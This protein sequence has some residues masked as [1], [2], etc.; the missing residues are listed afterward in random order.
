M[1]NSAKRSISPV[2]LG[3]A[4][5]ACASCPA[6]AQ[7]S[8]EE[9]L[10]QEVVVTAQFRAQNLQRTPI[11][12]T[13]VNAEMMDA[14]S[15]TSIYEVS[16][17]APSVTL[18]PQGAAFGP[19]LAA[20]IRGVGQYDFNP[21][22]EPGVG[23]YVDDVY[24]STLTG[25]VFDLLDL[26][27]VEILRGPQGTL[28]GK[29]SIGGAVKLYSRKP[30]GD[31]TGFVQG[32]YGS[33]DRLDLRASGDFTIANG[34]FARLSGVAKK[35]QGY[36]DRIDY[37][38][39]FPSSG[40]TPQLS[41]NTDCVLAKEGEVNYNAVRAMVRFDNG[42]PVEVNLIGDYIDSDSAQAASVLLAANPN[43]TTRDVN[44]YDTSI[45][46]DSRFVPPAGSYYNYAGYRN[47]ADAGKPLR[48][49]NGRMYYRGWGV[50]GEVNWALTERLNLVS[51]SAYRTYDSGFSNDNDLSPLAL[52][53]G[54]G[55]L[56]FHSFSQ[57][58]RLNGAF[59]A[60]NGEE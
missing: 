6:L 2:G 49:A 23:M 37:G 43:A 59:G 5:L 16:D 26:D 9:G 47:E 7:E 28:A 45:A 51:I 8:S 25:A 34:V 38:C 4:A 32:T 17:Q 42:G 22:Y 50:S 52:T 24:Y 14:R 40:V 20:S 27:R 21:A 29:N 13:A 1:H 53:L 18:K 10:L 46:Y 57:E 44:P 36:V 11:A 56:D 19:S 54:D 30:Q 31:N 35:Q 41:Y 58:I 12:I 39:A 55:T 33:R 48:V 15:Q 60:S 3:F